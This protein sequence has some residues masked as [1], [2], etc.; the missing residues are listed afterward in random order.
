MKLRLLS[1]INKHLVT[2]WDIDDDEQDRRKRKAEDIISLREKNSDQIRKGRMPPSS[3]QPS[4]HVISLRRK[5]ASKTLCK[6]NHRSR[7]RNQFLVY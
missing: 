5:G 3:R 2:K 6:V 1:I 7:R 4:S